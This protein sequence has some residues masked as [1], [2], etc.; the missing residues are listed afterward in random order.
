[1]DREPP[2]ATSRAAAPLQEESQQREPLEASLADQLQLLW[3]LELGDTP[4]AVQ[5]EPS[6]SRA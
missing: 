5:F 2:V 1:M 4:M 6:S 3:Q